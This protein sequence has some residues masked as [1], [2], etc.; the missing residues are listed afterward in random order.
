[1]FAD[2][3]GSTEVVS[4]DDPEHASEWLERIVDVM[5][6]AVH[7]FGGT[8]NRVQGDGIMA[9]FG[10]P[11]DMKT[12]PFGRVQQPWR[13]SMGSTANRQIRDPGQTSGSGLLRA[14]S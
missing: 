4:K 10:A 6:R 2:V 14:R 13:C 8:V 7:Q 12:M 5:R 9:L 3:K 1:M 11:V